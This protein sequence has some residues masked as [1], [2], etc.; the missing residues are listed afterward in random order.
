[1]ALPVTAWPLMA[2]PMIP[3]MP[4]FL[5]IP[6]FLLMPAHPRKPERSNLR[7]DEFSPWITVKDASGSP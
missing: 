3:L 1:M 6:S 2:W 4:S 5:L 7:R